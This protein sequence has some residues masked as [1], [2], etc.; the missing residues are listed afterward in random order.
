[1]KDLIRKNI[2]L[3]SRLTGGRGSSPSIHKAREAAKAEALAKQIIKDEREAYIDNETFDTLVILRAK[4]AAKL[5]QLTLEKEFEQIIIA[6]EIKSGKR[7]KSGKIARNKKSPEERKRVAVI[8]R[9]RRTIQS[10]YAQQVAGFRYRDGKLIDPISTGPAPDKPLQPLTP[11]ERLQHR[12]QSMTRYRKR[13]VDM[14]IASGVRDQ[15][16]KWIG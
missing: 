6:S 7:D 4:K 1:M 10:R 15:N 12:A 2:K 13:I 16:G 11:E 8:G 5:E 9:L 3:T 14:E